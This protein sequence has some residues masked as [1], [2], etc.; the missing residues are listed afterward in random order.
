MRVL[1][2]RESVSGSWLVLLVA[3][4]GV[5]APTLVEDAGVT[6]DQGDSSAQ[7]ASVGAPCG[8]T[9][10]AGSVAFA[11]NPG[12]SECGGGICLS[13]VAQPGAATY[14]GA[15]CTATCNEDSDCDGELRD[16]GDPLDT[17]CQTGF[18]CGIAFVK[19]K[20]CCV[21]MCICKDFVGPGGL[22]TPIAC[23]GAAAETCDQ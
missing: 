17:R 23:Q 2:G 15:Y 5:D 10:D 19:G 22:P 3:A 13:S 20:L 1:R 12:A 18:L 16:P 4:C 9:T 6:P 14:T 8:N 7:L 11:V 21:R